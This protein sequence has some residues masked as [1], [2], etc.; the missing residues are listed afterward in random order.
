MLQSSQR[1]IF[2]SLKVLLNFKN[3]CLLFTCTSSRI[4]LGYFYLYFSSFFLSYLYFYSSY[5]YINVVLLPA[6]IMCVRDCAFVVH[7]ATHAHARVYIQYMCVRVPAMCMSAYMSL[8]AGCT[9]MAML[10][11]HCHWH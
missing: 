3:N 2:W 10:E 4:F 6:L 9:C 1:N 5:K 11:L 8:C 7:E